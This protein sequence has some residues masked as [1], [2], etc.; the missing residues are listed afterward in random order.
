MCLSKKDIETIDRAQSEVNEASF[1]Q[2]WL[3]YG[4][5]GTG[6]TILA[7]NRVER[8]SRMLPNET[9]LFVSKSKVLGRWVEQ[10]ADELGISSKIATFDRYVWNLVKNT[11]G[12][13]P[14]KMEPNAQWSEIDWDATIPLLKV[15]SQKNPNPSKI[16][17][18]LDE[19]QDVRLGFF[20]ACEFMFKRLFI[21]MDENQKTEVFANSKR[22][23]IVRL[24][25]ID[26]KHQKLL[27]INYRNPLEI[28]ELSETFFD[29]EAGE[30]ASVPDAK[31]R[32]NLEAPPVIRWLSLS[33]EKSPMDQVGRIISYCKDSPA[34]TVCVVVP[35][36]NRVKFMSRLLEERAL[37][38]ERIKRLTNWTVRSYVSETFSRV[39][40]DMCSP[41]VI[42][43]SSI[44]FKGSEFNSVFFVE[45]EQ[46][47]EKPASMYTA[48]TRA[49]G[50]IEVLADVSES[51]KSQIRIQFEQAL[52]ENLIAEVALS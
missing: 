51:S 31:D 40:L 45:W 30:L 18:V 46:S 32:R 5:A 33:D 37:A 50:R 36:S 41:G 49:R 7:L 27:H 1:D 25:Q 13:D 19:A 29:G 2:N 52:G 17:L 20:S 34:A 4:P 43:S 16:N 3:V 15:A 11:I 35:N 42:V 24:L 14:V 9:T 39:T 28:K 47:V 21:L 22:S 10:A 26:E 8:M 6:K 48:I 23:D 38:D 12:Q 44:N